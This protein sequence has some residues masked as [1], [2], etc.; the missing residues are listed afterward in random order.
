MIN[1]VRILVSGRVQ[2]VYFRKYTFDTAARLGLTGYVMN[3]PDG[4]VRIEATGEEAVL[5]SLISWCRSGS[6]GAEVQE[7]EVTKLPLT[8]YNGFTIRY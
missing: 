8:Q 4:K 5:N 7:V 1:T 6:P 3:Q 2:G